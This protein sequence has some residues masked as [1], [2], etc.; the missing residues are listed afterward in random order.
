M[1]WNKMIKV[2]CTKISAIVWANGCK[3]G[4]YRCTACGNKGHIKA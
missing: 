4:D 3:D 1:I 2:L